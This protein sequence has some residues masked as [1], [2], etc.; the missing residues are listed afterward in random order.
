MCRKFRLE[1]YNIRLKLT[2][3]IV[4]FYPF[5]GP[6]GPLGLPSIGPSVRLSI[7]ANVSSSSFPLLL[8]S[9]SLLY[10]FIQRPDLASCPPQLQLI[11]YLTT[12]KDCQMSSRGL[13]ACLL[14]TLLP[15]IENFLVCKVRQY[16]KL[17]HCKFCRAL[18][19]QYVFKTCMFVHGFEFQMILKNII[20]YPQNIFRSNSMQT[21]WHFWPF[22]ASDFSATCISFPDSLWNAPRGRRNNIL[23]MTSIRYNLG[24]TSLGLR[25]LFQHHQQREPV[26]VPSQ[27]DGPHSPAPPRSQEDS[28][29][30]R[31]LW[32]DWRNLSPPPLLSHPDRK[33][34]HH[35]LCFHVPH[36]RWREISTNCEFINVLGFRF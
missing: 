11:S 33:G 4:S 2:A 19:S 13:R 10:N 27:S 26:A 12:L 36:F 24:K 20:I 31:W 15:S 35:I 21:E 23:W 28:S 34:N 7:R 9:P 18:L 17:Y 25:I 29:H 6:R 5:F 3:V 16:F 1:T 8:S 30:L 22:L 14:R 32:M